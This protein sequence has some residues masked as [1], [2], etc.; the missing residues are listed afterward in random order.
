[1]ID[2]REE[3]KMS[4][5]TIAKNAVCPGTVQTPKSSSVKMQPVAAINGTDDQT[6]F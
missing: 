6:V 5:A 2:V 3:I 4:A 1:V